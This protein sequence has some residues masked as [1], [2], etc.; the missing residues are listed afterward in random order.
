M[1]QRVKKPPPP[2]S[3]AN[4]YYDPSHPASYGSALALSKAVPGATLASTKNWLSGESTYTLHRPARKRFI[5]DPIVVAGLDAQWSFDLIDVSTISGENKGYKYLLTVIDA[6]SKFAWVVALR[7]KTSANVTKAMANIFKTSGRV[8]RHARSDRGTE[9]MGAPF[10]KLLKERNVN[11]FTADNYTKAAIVE[12]FNRTLRSRLWKFFEATNTKHYLDVLPAIVRSYNSRVHRTT[13]MPPADV[14]P[15]N[16]HKV[17][18]RMYG[19]LVN[20]KKRKPKLKI[21]DLVRLSKSKKTFEKGY[22]SNYTEEIFVIRSISRSGVRPRYKVE[23]LNGELILGSFLLEELQPVKR[24]E[25]VVRKVLRSSKDHKIVTWRG[26]P[27]TL[28]V[29]IPKQ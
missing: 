7:D 11:F 28:R 8:P 14:T 27:Q 9:F 5:H 29:K 20:Q 4:I 21:N 6:L 15:Y 23:D 2:S 3:Y 12:R 24:V 18:N 10:Q 22:S 1:G 19:H 13:G 16:A 26:Y 25:R 17:W